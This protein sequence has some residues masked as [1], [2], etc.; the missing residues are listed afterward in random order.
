MKGIRKIIV[1]FLSI[2]MVISMVNVLP[3]DNI[4]NV[5]AAETFAI[6]APVANSTVAAGYIDIK[7]ND[8]SSYGTVTNYKVYIN[9]SLAATTKNLSYTFYTTKVYYHSAWVVAELSNGSKINTPT[10]KFGVTKK[11]LG[12]ATD[13][14]ANLNIK[15][16]GVAWYYNWGENPSSGSQYQGVEYVPM[17]WKETSATNLKNRVNSAKSK[18]YKYVLTYNEPDLQGQCNMTVNAVYTAWQGLD[19]MTGIKISSPVTAL[20]PKASSNWFQPFM[21]KIDV[22]ND[23][24]PDFISIHCYPDNYAGKS[25]ANWFVKEVV[26][27]TWN[28]Y[29]KPIWIT[30][31]STTG[32]NVTATGGNGTKEFWETVMPLLDQRD[33]V[34]RYAAFDFNSDTTGLWRYYTTKLTPAGEVYSKLGNPT[35]DYN[36]GDNKNTGSTIVTV[37]KPAKAKIKSAKNVKGKKIKVTL[38][39]IS[40]AKGYQIRWC[41]NRKFDGYDSKTITKLKYTIKGLEKRTNCYIKV[42]AYKKDGS[43][44]LYGKWSSIKKVKV[45]K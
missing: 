32:A 43:K 4:K 24:D 12:L 27:W 7:W 10:I 22:N 18:G 9:G 6:T 19:G 37:K 14:G 39:K 33:Y 20:W 38:K 35:Q 30:E 34:E 11:G 2:A 28:T 36:T 16:M 41:E 5:D 31:F 40:G 42:R 15:G 17:V 13:M 45:K 29:H 26:D 21:S 23:Y 3:S 8:A 25:M 44:K 1:T